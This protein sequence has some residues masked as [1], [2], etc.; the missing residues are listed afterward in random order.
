MGTKVYNQ[1]TSQWE[2]TAA[3]GLGSP[4]SAD[5][6][7]VELDSGAMSVA[8]SALHA[9]VICDGVNTLPDGYTY[10]NT[11]G[12]L[13]VAEDGWYRFDAFHVWAAS[14]AGARNVQ[15]AMSSHEPDEGMPEV[16]VP[17]DGMYSNR[18]VSPFPP[19][20][21][22]AGATVSM[23]VRQTSGGALNL[24]FF[25]WGCVKM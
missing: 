15:L 21:L 20:H 17:A 12:V 16:I 1:A 19:V 4:A 7:D 3:G 14:T 2:D 13:T 23:K 10:D 5:R 11:T 9:V 18:A 8:D 22:P 6:F 25:E 24:T